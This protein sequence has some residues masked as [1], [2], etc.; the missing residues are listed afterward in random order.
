MSPYYR[1]IS[2]VLLVLLIATLVGLVITSRPIGEPRSGPSYRNAPF[3]RLA[4]VTQ[5]QFDTARAVAAHAVTR[6][7]QWMAREVLR[8]ADIEVD[9][10]FATALQ[11]ATDHPTPLS[12]E[13][14]EISDR[15]KKAQ[16]Q[17]DFDQAEIERLK[18]G[19][20]GAKESAKD[21]L[22]QQLQSIQAQAD[23]DQDELDDAHQDL[24]RAGGDPQGIIQRMKQRYEAREQANG[25]LQNL[26]PS[27]TQNSV[28]ETP[29]R[30]IVALA[31][32]WYS[33]REKIVQ[34]QQAEQGV[35]A[36]AANLANRRE[37]LNQKEGKQTAREP[38]PP[39]GGPHAAQAAG[40]TAP[41]PSKPGA[42][43]MSS[44]K[45]R[46]ADRKN[47]EVLDKRIEDETQLADTYKRWST[48]VQERERQCV[49]RLLYCLLWILIIAL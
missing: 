10:A 17:L 11:E 41:A 29:S 43:R 49:H 15:L 37:K 12:P 45:R 23:L 14:Q 42:A 7:E 9:L 13:A 2:A 33:L 26:V 32:T 24:I 1:V 25:G 6:E 36:Q 20:A 22:Q 31:R 34:L 38:T 21:A 16:A 8:I 39:A 46:A 35:R 5:D 28:E 19:L 30:N 4:K 3:Y 44:L 27:G 40:A 18:K 47:L 48:F